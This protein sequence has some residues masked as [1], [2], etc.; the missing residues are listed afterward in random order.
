MH[1]HKLL[2]YSMVDYDCIGNVVL[3]LSRVELLKSNTAFSFCSVSFLII[4]LDRGTSGVTLIILEVLHWGN[5]SSTLAYLE[6]LKTLALI[7][8]EV[9]PIQC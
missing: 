7:M 2:G 6:L 5:V 3:L 1:I 9:I 8:H 4:K